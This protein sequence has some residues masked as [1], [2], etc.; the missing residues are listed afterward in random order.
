MI[1]SY[2]VQNLHYLRNFYKTLHYLHKEGDNMTG[3]LPPM[4]PSNIPSVVWLSQYHFIHQGEE[5]F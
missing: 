3:Y 4:L 1:S 5:N 2:F